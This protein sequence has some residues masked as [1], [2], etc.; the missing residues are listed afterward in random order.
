M[1]ETLACSLLK[2]LNMSG[3]TWPE[4]A[5]IVLDLGYEC[6]IKLAGAIVVKEKEDFL[7]NT[8]CFFDSKEVRYIKDLC[9]AL[10]L[11]VGHSKSVQMMSSLSE[12]SMMFNI[13]FQ[14]F[15]ES[16]QEMLITVLTVGN[17]LY[18]TT[19][20]QQ[21]HKAISK[22]SLIQYLQPLLL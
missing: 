3:L 19:I 2:Q 14:F 4:Y 12:M 6:N 5:W 18:Y 10:F 9:K 21:A 20:S 11:I 1:R 15:N 22:S 16:E 7:I 17:F 8:S 13:S